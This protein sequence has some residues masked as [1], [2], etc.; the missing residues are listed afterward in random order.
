MNL[1][2]YLP[3]VRS[4]DLLGGAPFTAKVLPVGTIDV[5][6]EPKVVLHAFA[7]GGITDWP[8]RHLDCAI[9]SIV[10]QIL[11]PFSRAIAF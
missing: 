7:A 9:V 5:I 3:R 4:S 1:A 2:L 10:D 8:K 6:F 11:A